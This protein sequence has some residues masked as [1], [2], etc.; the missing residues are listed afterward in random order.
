MLLLILLP[1]LKPLLLGTFDILLSIL[2]IPAGE[3]RQPDQK[4]SKAIREK[5]N[6]IPLSKYPS[7]EQPDVNIFFFVLFG[8]IIKGPVQILYLCI[9]FLLTLLER[10]V[11]LVYRIQCQLV[12]NERERVIIKVLPRQEGC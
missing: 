5:S 9:N 4:R 6:L 11:G 1:R 8:K 12:K 2:L 3:L 7:T 10:Q